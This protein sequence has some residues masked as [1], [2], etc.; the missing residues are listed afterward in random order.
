MAV[1]FVDCGLQLAQI[2]VVV[3]D[4]LPLLDSVALLIG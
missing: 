3:T 4:T 2:C 1:F